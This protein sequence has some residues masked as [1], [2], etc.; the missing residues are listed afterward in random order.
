MTRPYLRWQRAHDRYLYYL[1]LESGIY[2]EEKGDFIY[3]SSGEIKL[4]GGWTAVAEK[5]TAAFGREFTYNS[6]RDR[7]QKLVFAENGNYIDKLFNEVMKFRDDMEH[8]QS[9]MES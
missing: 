7:F 4:E 5:M 3:T 6:V 8:V 1:T 9:V 2:D